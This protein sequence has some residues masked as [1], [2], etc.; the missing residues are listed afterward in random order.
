[1]IRRRLSIR[2][3]ATA[4]DATASAQP[5][6]GIIV[7]VRRPCCSFQRISVDVRRSD[8]TTRLLRFRCLG[9]RWRNISG[10]SLAAV[11]VVVPGKTQTSLAVHPPNGLPYVYLFLFID[12]FSV[13]TPKQLFGPLTAKSQPTWLKFYTHHCYTE[14]TKRA[15]LDRDRCM[16]DS[17]PNQNDYVFV[18]LVTHPKSYRR[19]QMTDCCDFGGKPSK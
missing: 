1:M 2:P 17:R 5:H 11:V 8:M 7:I 6:R 16:G 14:Y 4:T 19:T 9:R 15:A 18:I 13:F 12:P 3:V 10:E